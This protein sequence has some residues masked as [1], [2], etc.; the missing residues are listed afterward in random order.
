MA[1]PR[2]NPLNG[3]SSAEKSSLQ[4]AKRTEKGMDKDSQYLEFITRTNG[5]ISMA[6]YVIII[7]HFMSLLI[8]N[9]DY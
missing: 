1:V 4:D 7:C 5:Y 3:D 2:K 6:N 8:D 9:Y